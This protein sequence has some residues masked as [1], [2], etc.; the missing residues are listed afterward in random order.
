MRKTK[1]VYLT[2]DE[3]AS[4]LDDV[5]IKIRRIKAEIR[6]SFAPADSKDRLAEAAA[7]YRKMFN[8]FIN[9]VYWGDAS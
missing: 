2:D 6:S 1:K 9:N 4:I 5:M 3:L 8:V 7:M